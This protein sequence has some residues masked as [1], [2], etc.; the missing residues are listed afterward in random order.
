[1]V[2]YLGTG[3][4]NV[5]YA[6]PW[7]VWNSTGTGTVGSVWYAWN[8][9]TSGTNATA[10]QVWQAW[11]TY[12]TASTIADPWSTWNGDSC[13]PELR[14]CPPPPP[15]TREQLEARERHLRECN[16]RCAAERVAR[17]EAEARAE[18]LL[19]R[20]LDEH[21]REEY[22]REKA[23]TVRLP[24]GKRYRIKKGWAGNV[25][26]LE[27][28]RIAI[29]QEE[30]PSLVANDR[31]YR[32]V[33]RFCIHPAEQL[34]EQDNMLAQLLLLKANEAEFRRIANITRLQA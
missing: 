8:T 25:E 23:F 34:P 12:V 29:L 18:A 30:A 21:Q 27:A 5:Y 15:L 24:D 11:Q 14:A 10:N 1:V 7:S 28:R 17:Q 20:E 19:L 9:L 13:R 4:T 2:Y 16:A 22:R 26:R 33:E 3:G 6:D 31:E 32:A